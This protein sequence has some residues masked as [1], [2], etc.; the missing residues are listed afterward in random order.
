M[1]KRLDSG[2]NGKYLAPRL[3]VALYAGIKWYFMSVFYSICCQLLSGMHLLV[4]KDFD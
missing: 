2:S 4:L 1:S 3:S